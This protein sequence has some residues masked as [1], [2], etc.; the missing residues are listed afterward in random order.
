LKKEKLNSLEK[1]EK[2]K[3]DWICIF[4]NSKEGEKINQGY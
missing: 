3:F 4:D 2:I 1:T